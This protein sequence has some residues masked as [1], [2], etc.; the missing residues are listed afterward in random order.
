MLTRYTTMATAATSKNGQCSRQRAGVVVVI[1]KGLTERTRTG[2]S[3]KARRAREESRAARSLAAGSRAHA[4]HV[5]AECR[6]LVLP[7][8]DAHGVG[9]SQTGRMR[10]AGDRA[11]DRRLE[12]LVRASDLARAGQ[13]AVRLGVA[14]HLGHICGDHRQTRR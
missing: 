10:I 4:L 2:A 5:L 13:L 1:S 6:H 8:L 11:R 14:L 3:R 12:L 7:G 9:A